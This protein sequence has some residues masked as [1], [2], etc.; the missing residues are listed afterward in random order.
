MSM[1]Y[2]IPDDFDVNDTDVN[3]R[4]QRNVFPG[5]D[6]IDVT[7]QQ[8]REHFRRTKKN[9]GVALKNR[10]IGV[11]VGCKSLSVEG[12]EDIKSIYHDLISKRLGTRGMQVL[13]QESL[14]ILHLCDAAIDMRDENRNQMK[15]YH[16]FIV[17]YCQCQKLYFWSLSSI[18]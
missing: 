3:W 11:G 13:D 9:T 14:R 4:A 7:I 1:I 18:L 12:Q 8:I 16:S 17:H 6:T 10:V 2:D 15:N 5:L